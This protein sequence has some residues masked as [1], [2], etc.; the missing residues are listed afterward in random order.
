M[1]MCLSVLSFFTVKSQDVITLKNGDEIK[2]KITDVGT[3]EIKYKKS[4]SSPSYTIKKSDVFMIRYQDGTK[5]TFK[6]EK[7]SDEN[8]SKSSDDMY[9]KGQN[10]ADRY[11]TGKNCGAGGTFAT[12]IGVGAVLGLI[13][14]IACGSTIP[15]TENLVIQNRNL[16]NN[17]NYLKGYK[18]EAHKIKKH[19]VWRWYG[20]GVGVNIL[21]YIILLGGI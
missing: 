6:E 15:K 12:T 14:A 5:E 1:I 16:L 13:P 18:D 8:T 7:T 4:D 11:Y 19:K 10:D 20:I 21:V 2:A 9:L 17:D 3:D